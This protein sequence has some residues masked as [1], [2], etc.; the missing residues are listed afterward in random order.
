MKR[1]FHHHGTDYYITSRHIYDVAR[2]YIRTKL[3]CE[4]CQEKL[5]ACA[6]GKRAKIVLLPG[7]SHWL[8]DATGIQIPG[9]RLDFPINGNCPFKMDGR[10]M[11]EFNKPFDCLS[12]PFQP[13]FDV[14]RHA[15]VPAFAKNCRHQSE[16][17]DPEWILDRWR[18]WLF[19]FEHVDPRWFSFYAKIPVSEEK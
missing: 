18:A 10:C 15:L 2:S 16:D 11:A 7:E 13:T 17:M 5:C 14:T 9:T 8:F 1:W 19:L 3:P 12:F 6:S 4:G